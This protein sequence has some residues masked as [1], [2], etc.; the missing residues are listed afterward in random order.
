VAIFLGLLWFLFGTII[1]SFLNVVILRYHTGRSIQGRSS[2]PSCGTTLSAFELIPIISF[3]IQK[4]RCRPCGSGLSLQYP[5]VETLTGLLFFATWLHFGYAYY[6]LYLLFALSL[7][8]VIVVY[9]IRHTIIPDAFV[10]GFIA[11]AALSLVVDFQT[12]TLLWPTLTHVLAGPI[13]FTPFFLLWLVSK[14][15]WIGLGDGKLVFGFGWLLGLSKG[16]AATLLGF[17]IGAAVSVCILIGQSWLF[18]SPKRLT[19]KSELPLAPFLILGF[20]I[21]LFLDVD[22]AKLTSLS[23]FSF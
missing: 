9:D 7:L 21:A 23:L 11:L 10:Y 5:L 3:L 15:R 20:L 2:C 16:I 12:L 8:V 17:W 6:G 14:G 18:R 13:L 19:M 4:G 1:G 22:F